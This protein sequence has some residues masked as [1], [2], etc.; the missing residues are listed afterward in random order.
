MHIDPF[1]C[2]N[3]DFRTTSDV[4]LNKC[5]LSSSLAFCCLSVVLPFLSFFLSL[6][7]LIAV[8]DIYGTRLAYWFQNLMLH[9]RVG[10][11]WSFV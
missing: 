9:L 10:T 8:D 5:S 7:L 6:W 11:D 1:I 2:V 3:L 4:G